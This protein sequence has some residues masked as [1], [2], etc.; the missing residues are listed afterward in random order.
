MA[1]MAADGR[2]KGVV[3]SPGV[4]HAQAPGV[5][6]GMTD[7]AGRV[8][9]AHMAVQPAPFPHPP[10]P[11]IQARCTTIPI[12]EVALFPRQCANCPVHIGERT[13]WTFLDLDI[14]KD[15]YLCEDC[16]MKEAPRMG[17]LL[18]ADQ[19]FD[20]DLTDDPP[21][22]VDAPAPSPP[23]VV[24]EPPASTQLERLEQNYVDRM[25]LNW[26]KTAK[27]YLQQIAHFTGET[28]LNIK[29]RLGKRV[30]VKR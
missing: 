26:Q 13:A 5:Y 30:K 8:R 18:T 17:E 19:V 12:G 10:S 9:P 22:K 20:D 25:N 24:D 21:V 16:W 15:V 29:Q 28:A 23:L 6:L 27:G 4:L 2:P 7:P 14:G 11:P 1:K 3:V